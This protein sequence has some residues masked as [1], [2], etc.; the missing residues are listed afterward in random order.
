MKL[1]F[2]I[3][4]TSTVFLKDL[5]NTLKS[6]IRVFLHSKFSLIINKIKVDEASSCFILGNGPSLK[7]DLEKNI[8]SISQHDIFVVNDFFK[9]ELYTIIK[10]KYY[11][12]I[13][14]FYW[15]EKT[16]NEN[17]VLIQKIASRTTWKMLL[18]IP[19]EAYKTNFY[20][21]YLSDHQYISIVN[22]NSTF[23]NGFDFV[24]YWFYEKNLAMPITQNV[25]IPTIF[26]AIQFGYGQINILGSDHS[27][28]QSLSVN[29]NNEVCLID[30]HF[31]DNEEQKLIPWKKLNGEIYKMSEI[32]KDLARMFEGYDELR[33]YAEYKKINIFNYCKSSFIDAFERK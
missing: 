25:M 11:V 28:T 2:R 27:W 32:L 19:N 3:Y 9:S 29:S 22:F 16:L 26:F 12:L 23:F 13:D 14:P 8:N 24:K 30:S 21:T 31:Y 6:L 7:I 1:I 17:I 33:T 20:Q 5:L 18:L 4:I 15:D 10:P